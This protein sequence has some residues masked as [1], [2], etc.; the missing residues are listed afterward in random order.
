MD[1]VTLK[2]KVDKDTSEISGFVGT[3]ASNEIVFTKNT[4]EALNFVATGLR[5]R[6]GD[7]VIISNLDHQSNII[8]WMLLEQE[9]IRLKIAYADESGIVR[10]ENVRSLLTKKTKLVS[11]TQVSN[12]LGTIQ[13]VKEIG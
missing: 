1:S 9:K 6:E 13:P 12:T 10:A 2:D 8:P 7:E 11:I 3:E 5:F 4:T